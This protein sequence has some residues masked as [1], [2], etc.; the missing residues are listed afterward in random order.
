MKKILT[1]FSAFALLLI[2][3]Q[4]NANAG[5]PLTGTKTIPGTYA[6][7]AA[8]IT[9]LNA[10]GVGTGGVIFNIAPGHTETVPSGGLIINITTDLPT[11]GNPVVF[12]RGSAGANPII[13]TDVS[14][15]GIISGTTLGGTGDAI[16]WLVGT[17]YITFNNINF[18]E[19]YTGGTQSL[20][21]EYGILMVRASS[22]D[23]CRNVTINGCTIQQQQ[24]NI[25]SSCIST[26]NRDAAGVTTNPTTTDGRHESI[27]VQ[28]CTL[29]N[30]FNGMWFVGYAAPDPR[31]L[32]D[33]FYNIGGTTGNTLSNIGTGLA[34][35]TTGSHYGIY[36]Q[37][38]DSLTVS[39]NT[40]RVN[41]GSN[42][43]SAYGIY[44]TTGIN[45][46]ATISN[47]N[48]SD[49][50][51]GTS[52]THY[53][54]YDGIGATG[55][56]N[57]VNITN[58]T[59]HSCRYDGATTGVNYYIYVGTNPYNVNVTGN[60][61]RDN[62]IGNG[63]STATGSNYAIYRASSNTTFGS[64]YTVAN[65]TIKNIRR[66][67]SVPGTGTNYMIYIS[68]GAY[69][70]EVNN[71]TIDSIFS[72]S[73]S[74]S[75]AGIYCSYTAAGM[76]SIHDNTVSNL[77]KVSG[78]SGSVYGIYNSNS[79]DSTST[80]N[81][82]IF[83]LY[84]NA[85]TG[86]LYGY[87]NFGSA[88]GGYENVYNNTIHD[89]TNNSSGVCIGM[90]VATGT[91]VNTLEKNVY[92]NLVYNIENDSIGQTGGI[93]VD[94]ANTGF[95]HS[96]RV[97]NISNNENDAS[98]PAAYGMLLG[99]TTIAA[100]YTVF[101]NM[102]SEVYAPISNSSLGVLGLWI[103]GGALSQVY[104]N[105]IYMDGSASGTNTG[106]YA[107]YVAGTTDA[108]LKNNIIVNKF[109]P[110]G[111]GANIA[112]F[113][114][115]GVIY[116]TASNNNNVY[117]PAGASNFIYY[118]GAA[119]H[120]TFANFQTAVAPAETN[121]F[122]ENSPFVNV[123]STPYN[124]DMSTIIATL[125]EGG[126]MPIA[127][128]TTDIHGTTRNGTTPDVGADEFDGIG[129]VTVAPV[130]VAPANGALLVPLNPLM[131]WNTA[132]NSSEY[133]IQISTDST[134]GT[135]TLDVDTVTAS[136]LQLPNNF[137]A[138]NTKYYW[139][140][141]GKN[142]IGEG[143]YSS[144]WNFTT[145]VT[146]IEPTSLPTVYELYRNYPNPFN[147]TTKIKFDIPENSFVSLKIYDITGRE[148]ANL[149][150]QEMAPG[151]YEFDWNASAYSSGV[152]FYRINAGSFVKTYKMIL[153]K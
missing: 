23:G 19:Q 138:V 127:G 65:N 114:A 117:V 105:T 116:N 113:K 67:Q 95:I 13:Q 56:D 50:L 145:G 68:S 9:D 49:T 12:Q 80:Y 148:V 98:L 37:Y 120:Q 26:A 122:T 52:S 78:T 134:F 101:N 8:A 147:P 27:S 39:N 89:L 151:R 4:A 17:D 121:S 115:T 31:D 107:L 42:S 112:I 77:M 51:G 14:G 45:S 96:N 81:N 140:V 40:V 38:Q 109:T 110:A 75:L 93:R 82:T 34:G 103:N 53:A 133:R 76:N 63:S 48:V 142:A 153:N 152:Y 62:Y 21:M 43:A 139:R 97:Y 123:S 124:L 119:T 72:T 94:Y 36:A 99:G 44:L 2:I 104:Y 100:N 136:Q 55:V 60:I 29:N 6:T 22:T 35:T 111:T 84:N 59:V 64:T 16:L 15:S 24:S 69:N 47:N 5:A 83:N 126:A 90:N 132:A 102:I 57:T 128:I 10:N 150:S 58:N 87:Y 92:G 79:T 85:T 144:V 143:P 11:A 25:Y 88:A 33:H 129:P 32:Y 73:T 70:Y 54:I 91:T 74:S 146:N 41:T 137:L 20:K 46:S 66:N 108:T 86:T 130:L 125:C 3:T 30:S 149:V 61:I 131:D 71:N 1:I 141:A 118:D 7:I 18:V 135:T 28:G 106:N